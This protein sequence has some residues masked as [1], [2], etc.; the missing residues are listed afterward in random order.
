MAIRWTITSLTDLESLH[1][2]ISDDNPAAV[3]ATAESILAGI[4]ALGQHPEMGRM[5]R[6]RGTRELVIAP[7]VVA[8]RIHR[9]A[10]EIV[11]ILHG[12]RRWP[13]RF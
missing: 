5:G 6:V 12:A 3:G 13:D 8:Y 4:A 2:Y 7:Y 1:D 9:K 11:A 10:I